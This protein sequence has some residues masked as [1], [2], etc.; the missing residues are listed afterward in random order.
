MVGSYPS[1]L[2]TMATDVYN[3]VVHAVVILFIHYGPWQADFEIKR[4][5]KGRSTSLR[6]E[7]CIR[8]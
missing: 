7:S 6:Y 1:T 4:G 5:L 3:W 8:L 2:V